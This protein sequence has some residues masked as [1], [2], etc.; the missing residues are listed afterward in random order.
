MR[1]LV[2]EGERRVRLREVAEPSAD[3][4]E[5]IVHVAAV[6]ICGS[7]LGIFR[8]GREGL[9]LPLV[10]GHEF[11]GRLD[12]GDFVV[13]NPI[14][15]C[16][17][18]AACDAGRTHVC[19]QRTVLG[20]RRAGGYAERV[21]VPRRSVVPAPGLT[22]TQAALV[23]PIANGVHAWRRA[24]CPTGRVAI[25]G[26]GAVG[27]SLLHVLAQRGLTDIT[28]IDPVP[29]RRD[30]A[31][32]G[33]ARE[34]DARLAGQ[35][36]VVFDAAGTEGTRAD[37][38]ACTAPGGTVAL[39]GLHDDRIALSAMAVVAFDRTLCGCFAYSEPEFAE[40][41]ELAR[42]ID[43][44]WAGAVAVDDAESALAD[45]IAGRGAPGRIKTMIRFDA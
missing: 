22:A 42:A 11:G 8:E 30:A 39:I 26:A 37:A 10:P 12:N 14:L 15:G 17:R 38:L 45:L 44:R 33:G 4:G 32:A 28:V 1:A 9:P 34:V 13:V 36:E 5:A 35:Y 21:A 16:G 31:R 19:A 20:I 18:C 23:E 6:G 25:I 41:I 29:E 40:A 3:A 24:G 2:Y 7:D 27:M 43:A